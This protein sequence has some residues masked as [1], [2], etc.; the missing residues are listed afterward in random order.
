MLLKLSLLKQ[1]Q[2]WYRG[3]AGGLRRGGFDVRTEK[4]TF[5][6]VVPTHRLVFIKEE[7]AARTDFRPTYA[8]P[9]RDSREW[10]HQAA[11]GNT[12]VCRNH[13]WCYCVAV[14]TAFLWNVTQRHLYELNR[15]L[16]VM[17]CIYTEA[18]TSPVNDLFIWSWTAEHFVSSVSI[19]ALQINHWSS[20]WHLIMT[21]ILQEWWFVGTCDEVRGTASIKSHSHT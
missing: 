19:W 17:N 13:L 16:L 14:Y 15:N 5:A 4:Q 18:I 11:A 6:C 2:K 12:A 10:N 9:S 20:V 21:E 1:C 8:R 7:Y 3:D